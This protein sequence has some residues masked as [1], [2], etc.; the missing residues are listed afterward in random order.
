MPKK[1]RRASGL[2]K[3][4][5]KAKEDRPL[6]PLSARQ[7]AFIEHFV[8]T[9]KLMQSAISAG[10]PPK[11]ADTA[12]ARLMANARVAHEIRIRRDKASES[13]EITRDRVLL[14]LARIGFANMADYMVPGLDGQP[15]LNLA[16]LSRAQAAALSEVT[17]EEFVDGRSDKRRVRRIKFKLGN[18][19]DALDRLGQHLGLFKQEIDV[20]HRHTLMGHM[21]DE[22]EAERRKAT[23]TI[24]HMPEGAE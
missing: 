16:G 18:K 4:I 19:V 7:L 22:I 11:S 3:V 14:E 17:V 6:P 15:R 20:N 1:S 2:N 10:Y 12:A 8:A 23:M 5:A 9:N 24:E 21:L 13:L